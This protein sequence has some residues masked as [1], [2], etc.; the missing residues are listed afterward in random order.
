MADVNICIWF[1]VIFVAMFLKSFGSH[2]K[3]PTSSAETQ[4]AKPAS[5]TLYFGAAPFGYTYTYH[6]IN[7]MS[8]DSRT[9]VIIPATCPLPTPYDR[10]PV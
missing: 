3:S 1:E 5:C 10:D 2:G 6:M 8:E 7:H 4:N 9:P